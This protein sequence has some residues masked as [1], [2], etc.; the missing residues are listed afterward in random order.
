[1][2]LFET[3][4]I[5]V[6]IEYENG[7]YWLKGETEN[8]NATEEFYECFLKYI[9]LYNVNIKFDKIELSRVN[10]V[11][12]RV[13]RHYEN[14][15]VRD[16]V[17]F[18]YNGYKAKLFILDKNNAL[19]MD[20]LG[21]YCTINEYPRELQKYECVIFQL[22]VMDTCI[23]LT[24]VVG[25]MFNTKFYI[26]SPLD[27]LALFEDFTSIPREN[28]LIPGEI[29]VGNKK[30]K[31]YAQSRITK[32]S[33]PLAAIDGY[34]IVSEFHEYKHKRPSCDVIIK[35]NKI[36]IATTVIGETIEYED[37]VY[38]ISNQDDGSIVVLRRRY[39]RQIGATELEYNTFKSLM[40]KYLNKD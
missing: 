37:G 35:N 19:Y 16:A 17:K 39:D 28:F 22:E 29:T 30:F 13:L 12:C 5:R 14:T 33:R 26:M 23:I 11:T 38:E 18:K 10:E 1:M 6:S 2:I 21:V 32:N 15:D 20:S 25:A 8:V 3:E 31:L 24:D 9:K 27:V 40:D 7:N 34:I 4:H 36:L